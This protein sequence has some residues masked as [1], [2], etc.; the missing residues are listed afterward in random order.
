M[1]RK[2]CVLILAATI[3][4][5]ALRL[6]RLSQRPMHGDE[7]V[8]AIKFGELLEKGFYKYDPYE[9]HGPTL[10]YLTLIPAWLTSAENI[11]EVNEFT[12]RIVPVFCGVLMVLFILFIADGLGSN[13]AVF[14]AI[15]TAVSP[16]MIYF[17]RYY[18]Q[19]VLLVC[20]TFGLIVS[21]YRYFQSRKIIWAILAGIF[22]GLM[23]ASKETCIIN[24]GSLILSLMIVHLILHRKNSFVNAF[25]SIKT[26][27]LIACILAAIV[28]SVSFFS[29]FFKN[30]HGIL[31]SILTYTTYF[32]RAGNNSLHI[33]PWYYYLRILLFYR[34][35]NGP[36]WTDA[37]I[38]ILAAIAFIAALKK[39]GLPFG[40]VNLVRLLGFYTLIQIIVYSAI[41]YKTPWCM[42][43]FIHGLILLA[44]VGAA[45]LISKTSKF[46]P[47]LIVSLLLLAG[48]GHLIWQAYLSNF[49]YYADSYNPYVYAHPTT[50]IYTLVEKVEHYARVD[51]QGKNMYIEVICPGND[52]WPLPWYLR[53]FT[54]V[55]YRDH[56]DMTEP[57]APLIIASPS[58]EA[59]LT[60]KIY[61][62]SIPFEQRHLY[63]FL[64]ED[65]P[66][67]IWLRPQIKLVGFVRE[68]LWDASQ[69]VSDPNELMR[70]SSEQ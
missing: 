58:V 63:M 41:P 20:F 60:K 67:Y 9:Y 17:S 21:G 27:H 62:D 69:N 56:V 45:I 6:P 51:P 2:C 61:D 22:A 39:K 26:S 59:D 43:G 47:R 57:S 10:N 46:L 13:S 65:N 33:N 29:S 50:E 53:S 37:F 16:A 54:A 18:V 64:F 14:A 32:N 44:G 31:D 38:V 3:V 35:E 5:L 8:H 70:N 19:E 52:Y 30:P 23:H 28:V 40:D 25:K 24:F 36:I 1:T 42:L 11:T 7:A 55:A 49:V 34:Y 48:T 15:L 66:Y 12:L 68:D 4:A